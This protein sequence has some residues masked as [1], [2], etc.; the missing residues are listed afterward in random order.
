MQSVISSSAMPAQ[1]Y[2]RPVKAK[3]QW[4][5]KQIEHKGAT[6]VSDALASASGKIALL[7]IMGGAAV[8]V[9][10]GLYDKAVITPIRVD[11]E[12]YRNFR[13]KSVH[14]CLIVFTG[15]PKSAQLDLADGLGSVL[16]KTK[17]D[18]CEIGAIDPRLCRN[19]MFFKP[20]FDL[21]TIKRLAFAS[22]ESIDELYIKDVVL[23]S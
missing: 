7:V 3:R 13:G 14:F 15:T 1:K 22:L 20:R 8:P 12:S 21:E 4:K 9:P 11:F 19:Y 10:D 6:S 17:A 18:V 16:V 23:S 5:A 2:H